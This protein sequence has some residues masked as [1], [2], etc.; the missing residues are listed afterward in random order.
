MESRLRYRST[1]VLSEPLQK[2]IDRLDA[3]PY[4]VAFMRFNRRSSEPIELTDDLYAQMQ[5]DGMQLYD[6]GIIASHYTQ[7]IDWEAFQIYQDRDIHLRE[8]DPQ[9]EQELLD[10]ILILSLRELIV[11]VDFETFCRL[12]IRPP[13]FFENYGWESD[14]GDGDGDDFLYEF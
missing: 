6:R 13:G 10:C 4:T 11:E 14:D 12:R 2:S 9:T 8:S 5:D 3:H 7:R 1:I